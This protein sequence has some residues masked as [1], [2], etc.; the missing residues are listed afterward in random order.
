MEEEVARIDHGRRRSRRHR[1]VVQLDLLGKAEILG[2]DIGPGADVG[3]HHV[4]GVTDQHDV[5][6]A[7]DPSSLD[8]GQQVMGHVLLVDDRDP[9]VTQQRGRRSARA[10]SLGRTARSSSFGRICRL[11]VHFRVGA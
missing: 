5:R 1:L 10:P 2:G 9:V 11:R 3:R 8:A 7:G 6:E 4:A